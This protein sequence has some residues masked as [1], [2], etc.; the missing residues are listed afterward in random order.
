MAKPR[1]FHAHETA[2]QDALDGLPLA[3]FGQRILGY[4][5]DFVLI[6]VLY[7]PPAVLWAMKV[8]HE[9]DVHIE[10]DF[11]HPSALVFIVVYFAGA[12]WAGGGRTPGKWIARTRVLSLTHDRLS[13]WQCI[14]RALGY[15]ASAL[16][17][18]FG[19][20]QFFLNR[21]RQTVHDRIAETIVVDERKRPS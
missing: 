11:H 12:L 19:F 7:A 6:V 3:N 4:L 8:R 1:H 10:V 16:E 9:K 17:L 5:I 21:N 13:L 20:L 14:E 18:G 2:R 15:G